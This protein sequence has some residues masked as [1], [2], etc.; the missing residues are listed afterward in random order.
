MSRQFYLTGASGSSQV[1]AG[2]GKVLHDDRP[3][4]P[5][6]GAAERLLSDAAPAAGL[7]LVESSVTSAGVNSSMV[8]TPRPFA[9]GRVGVED[10]H[11]V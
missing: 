3:V 11:R 4:R 1:V 10:G 6:R 7:T 9:V 8:T 2:P 5:R